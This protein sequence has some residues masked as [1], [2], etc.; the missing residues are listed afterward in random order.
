MPSF[1]SCECD[2]FNCANYYYYF[3]EHRFDM[4]HICSHVYIFCFSVILKCSNTGHVVDTLNELE[5]SCLSGE[6]CSAVNLNNWLPVIWTYLFIQLF[7][8]L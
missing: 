4:K 1:D 8:C 2:N 3:S 6:V 7:T 5:T